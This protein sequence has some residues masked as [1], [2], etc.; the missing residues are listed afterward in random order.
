LLDFTR[1]KA[2]SS[3][4]SLLILIQ[5][6]EWKKIRAMKSSLTYCDDEGRQLLNGAH[7]GA[8]QYV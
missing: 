6:Q 4:I 5:N 1:K 7:A 3:Q 2:I 8:F